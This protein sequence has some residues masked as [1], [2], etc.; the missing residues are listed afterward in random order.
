[1][2]TALSNIMNR[3]SRSLIL[4]SS[5]AFLFASDTGEWMT[6]GHDPGGQRFSPLTAINR[7][8]V[9]TLKVAW[10]FRT[11]DAY[12]PAHS[13]PTAFEATPLYIENTLYLGTP[14]DRIIALDPISG[15]QRWAYDPHINKD[16]G[17]GDYANRGVSTWKSATGQ[18]RIFIAAIDARLIAVHHRRRSR[19]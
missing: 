15:R 16:A 4:I 5:A 2:E 3:I 13:K 17:Y 14:L 11:G 18:R 8:N 10:T 6:Y 9:N 1:M 7:S 12:Q 19:P